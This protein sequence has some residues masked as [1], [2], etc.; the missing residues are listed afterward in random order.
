MLVLIVPYFA[1]TWRE[2]QLK[3]AAD[4]EVRI[5]KQTFSQTLGI[6]CHELRNPVHAL[7]GIISMLQEEDAVKAEASVCNELVAAEGSARTMQAVLDSVLELQQ[8]DLVCQYSPFE[9]MLM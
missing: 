5:A 7:Q 8:H 3:A 6:V 4:A 1:L 9:V 2:R